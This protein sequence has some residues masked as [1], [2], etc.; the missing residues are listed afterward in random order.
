M[1]LSKQ[2]QAL[3]THLVLHK[4]RMFKAVFIQPLTKQ[5]LVMKGQRMPIMEMKRRMMKPLLGINQCRCGRVER[6]MRNHALAR[7]IGH[8]GVEHLIPIAIKSL[9]EGEGNVKHAKTLNARSV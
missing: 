3:D 6:S 2:Q 8:Q 5:P 9:S 4:I 1:A 7:G